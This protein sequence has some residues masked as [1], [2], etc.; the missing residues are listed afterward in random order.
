M[1]SLLTLSMFV[2][3]G[4]FI[5]I[6][7]PSFRNDLHALVLTGLLIIRSPQGNMLWRN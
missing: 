1:F 7:I 5:V 2:Q 3:T 6:K 4:L